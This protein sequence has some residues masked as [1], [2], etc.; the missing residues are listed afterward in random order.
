MSNYLNIHL[1]YNVC[2]KLASLFASLEQM[3]NCSPACKGICLAG[4]HCCNSSR[5]GLNSN[6]GLC[7]GSPEGMSSQ[8]PCQLP[9]RL[10]AHVETYL[11]T[12]DFHKA[13]KPEHSWVS[14]LLHDSLHWMISGIGTPGATALIHLSNQGALQRPMTRMS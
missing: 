10:T 11:P 7:L 3:L 6:L 13:I 4:G 9:A 14:G 2:T 8:N 5:L 12:P 1:V